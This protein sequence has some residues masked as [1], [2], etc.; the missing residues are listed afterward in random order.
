MTGSKISKDCPLDLNEASQELDQRCRLQSSGSRSH[1]LSSKMTGI[2]ELCISRDFFT[3][4]TYPKR[5]EL[6]W[7]FQDPLAL[8]D[9]KGALRMDAPACETTR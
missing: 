8:H 1:I 3:N 7:E 9:G 5:S 6:A 2:R 4:R